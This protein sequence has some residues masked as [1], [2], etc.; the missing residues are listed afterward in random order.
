MA[1]MKKNIQG[2]ILALG[3][4][5]LVAPSWAQSHR[6]YRGAG[7]GH[8][9]IR[10]QGGLFT[11]RG[12]DDYWLDKELEFTGDADDFED[13]SVGVDYLRLVTGRVGLLVSGNA[14]TGETDQSYLDFVDESRFAIT[15]TTTLDTA[16]FNLGL[17]FYLA[18][19][20]SVVVPYV[21]IGG[22]FHFWRLEESG[23]FIDFSLP[24]LEI[25][26]DT[27]EAEGETFGYYY[28]VG[29]D[30]PLSSNFSIFAE[31]RWQ[32]AD[33][34]LEDDFEGFG[35]LDLGGRDLRAGVAWRF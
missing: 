3:L 32:R 11:P 7:Y 22:G 15:H 10:I 24:E 2:T 4:I 21:G 33:D 14:F 34:E 27:F 1:A 6:P 30:I 26:S 28:Q 17:L 12:E 18:S 23:D 5:L 29:L 20:N 8:N 9:L 19:R 13:F 25:F 16:S 35:T 31:G